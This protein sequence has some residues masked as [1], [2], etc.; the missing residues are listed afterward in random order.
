MQSRRFLAAQDPLK[1]VQDDFKWIPDASKTLQENS[2]EWLAGAFL[3]FSYIGGTQVFF[4]V[5]PFENTLFR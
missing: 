3:F 2:V 5:I 4:K 1:G